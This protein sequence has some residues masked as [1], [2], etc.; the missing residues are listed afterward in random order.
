MLK[1]E[2]F[3]AEEIELLALPCKQKTKLQR[4]GIDG[5]PL[6]I[7]ANHLRPYAK[8]RVRVEELLSGR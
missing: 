4:S 7:H 3:T 8:V 6:G 5:Q 1:L 2:L